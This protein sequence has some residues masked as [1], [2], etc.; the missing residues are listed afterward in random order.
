M[1]L[2]STRGVM[3]TTPPPVFGVLYHVG[4]DRIEDNIPA[5]LKEVAVFFDDDGLVPPLEE[6]TRLAVSP[7]VFLGIYTV[8]LPQSL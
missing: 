4:P 2:Y 6:M 7:I 5:E 1:S 3:V 8:Q